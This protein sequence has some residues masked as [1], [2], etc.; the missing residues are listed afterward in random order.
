VSFGQQAGPPATAKQVQYL[1]SLVQK[2]GY[3]GFRDARG[4]LQLNQRQGGGKF[5]RDEASALIER[6]LGESGEG[7]D[8]PAPAPSPKAAAAPKKVAAT[9]RE[10]PV[11]RLVAELERRGYTVTPPA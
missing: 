8:E 2:A 6:L 5:T 7:D 1:L 11:E 3:A 9:I 10:V 4:P